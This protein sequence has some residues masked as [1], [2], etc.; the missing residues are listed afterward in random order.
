M[1]LLSC[2][3]SSGESVAPAEKMQAE[4]LVSSP[5]VPWQHPW[6]GTG[7][8]SRLDLWAGKTPWKRERQPTPVLLPDSVESDSTE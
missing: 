6:V 2:P 3:R 8:P 1:T 5:W 7:C 4:P